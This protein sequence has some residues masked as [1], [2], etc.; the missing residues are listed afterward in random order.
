MKNNPTS[1]DKITLAKF[2]V[3][4]AWSDCEKAMEAQ[5][6]AI[7]FYQ[8]KA[9]RWCEAVKKLNRLEKERNGELTDTGPV[10]PASRET[11]SR[12]S[13]QRLVQPT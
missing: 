4:A 3:D 12:H 2:A 6:R 7:S 8:T 10:T 9:M 5:Y 11:Q 13:V 1:A